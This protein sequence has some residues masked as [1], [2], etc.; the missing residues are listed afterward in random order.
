VRVSLKAVPGVD[1]VDVSLEKGLAA[2]KMK[3]GNTATLKQ[4]NEAITKNGFTMK[5]SIATVAGTVVETNGK[6]ELHVSGSND[7]LTLIPD[8]VVPNAASESGKPVVVTGV[9]PEP[10]KGKTP[11]SIRY[12]SITE[13]QSK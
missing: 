11:D 5:N 8:G 1:L 9:V 13:E 2:V 4:L 3:P 7:V 6:A 10:G 12:R